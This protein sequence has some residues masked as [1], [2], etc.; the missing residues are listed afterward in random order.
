MIEI[1]NSKLIDLKSFI[2][3]PIDKK[4]LFFKQS[5]IIRNIISNESSKVKA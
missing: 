3:L 5:H 4:S 1:I 2:K